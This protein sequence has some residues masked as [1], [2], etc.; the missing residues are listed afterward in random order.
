MQNLYIKSM[1]LMESILQDMNQ[2][3]EDCWNGDPKRKA[4]LPNHGLLRV[5]QC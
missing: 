2:L 5:R 1:D 4:K 3:N